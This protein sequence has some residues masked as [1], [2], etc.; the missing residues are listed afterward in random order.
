M[1]LCLPSLHDTYD[2][3][4]DDVL[5]FL[6]DFLGDLVVFRLVSLGL[7][8]GFVGWHEHAP[9]VVV[10]ETSV[11]FNAFV[12]LEGGFLEV[13]FQQE[14]H[15]RVTEIDQSLLELLL[16]HLRQVL[17]LRPGQGLVLVEE[18]KNHSLNYVTNQV[19]L[20]G[21]ICGH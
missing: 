6:L 5:A 7:C 2:G 17:D 18:T 10:G 21:S 4:I 8:T 3:G 12:G 14:T 1:F 9:N 15:L 20:L 13:V 16:R 19:V 11:H